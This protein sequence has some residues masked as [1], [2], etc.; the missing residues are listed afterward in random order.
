MQSPEAEGNPVHRDAGTRY[1]VYHSMAHRKSQGAT[2]AAP[3]QRTI[4]PMPARIPTTSPTSGEC[5]MSV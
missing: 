3:L 1:T 5:S 2:Y 4:C